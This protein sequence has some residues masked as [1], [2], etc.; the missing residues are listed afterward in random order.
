MDTSADRAR[1]RKGFK[2]RGTTTEDTILKQR[3]EGRCFFCEKQG[4]IARNCPKKKS[5]GKQAEVEE[6]SDEE[7]PT[8]SKAESI[9]RLGRTMKEEDKIA[10]LQLAMNAEK[11][12]PEEQDF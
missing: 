11:A 8:E 1:A 6:D 3:K 12:G 2:A 9:I 7:E 5:S 10:L 4:H